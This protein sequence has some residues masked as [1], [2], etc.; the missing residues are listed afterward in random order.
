MRIGA[1][2]DFPEEHEKLESQTSYIETGTRLTRND[3]T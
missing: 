2:S 1:Q 3:T